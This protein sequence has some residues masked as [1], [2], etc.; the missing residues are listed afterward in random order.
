MR[1]TKHILCVISV[2][3][4]LISTSGVVMGEEAYVP[5]ENEELYGTWVN[6]EYKAKAVSWEYRV[7]VVYNSNGTWEEYNLEGTTTPPFRGSYT[8]ADK[9]TDPDGNV[10]YKV[11]LAGGFQGKSLVKISNSGNT[12]EFVSSRHG[13]DFPDELDANAEGYR[14]YYRK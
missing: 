5:T 6:P 12:C 4:M 2:L 8:I 14:I 9:W 10:W 7:K 11:A 3:G 13:G 1:N